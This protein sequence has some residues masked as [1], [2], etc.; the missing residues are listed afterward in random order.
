[1][2]A[3]EVLTIATA[4]PP[5]KTPREDTTTLVKKDTLEMDRIAQV[6]FMF[7]CVACFTC[8]SIFDAFSLSAKCPWPEGWGG[9]G[10]KR[11]TMEEFFIYRMLV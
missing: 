8:T 3:G 9:G 7:V 1:M 5:V 10:G 4:T 2:N 11:F 6:C